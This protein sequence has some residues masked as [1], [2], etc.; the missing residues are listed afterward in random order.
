VFNKHS[1]V[2]FKTE[3]LGKFYLILQSLMLEK[4]I[5]E[6][7]EKMLQVGINYLPKLLIGIVVLIVG[8]WLINRLVKF[9]AMAMRKKNMDPSLNTFLHSCISI[10]LRIL[11]LVTVAGMIGIHTTSLVAMLGAIGLAIGLAL[12][13]SLS[14]FAGGALILTFKPFKV[15]D[16]IE[17]GSH[18]GEVKEIQ[19]F[20]TVLLTTENKTVFI[21]NGV[22]SNGII[23]NYTVSGSIRGEVIFALSSEVDT[24]KVKG[25]V[26]EILKKDMR[27]HKNPMYQLLLTGF[28]NHVLRFT[29]RFYA[30][31]S[32]RSLIESDIW[33]QAKIAFAKHRI[34]EAEN[35]TVIR[36][37]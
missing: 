17:S 10:G 28:G 21:P 11:L 22:L 18:I 7:G 3:T 19:I 15:G 34:S 9:A 25:I 37:N 16:I 30:D 4:K 5:T 32:D 31:A 35:I 36:R 33:E 6:L 8:W 14:N 23:V 12:Q 27:I 29:V 1:F 20:N 24:D 26:E 13:G 2:I